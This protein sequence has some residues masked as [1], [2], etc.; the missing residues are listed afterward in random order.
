MKRKTGILLL[1]LGSIAIQ[2]QAQS[3]KLGLLMRE[4][5][6]L[7]AD[8]STGEANAQTRMQKMQIPAWGLGVW[9]NVGNHLGVHASVL[10][11]RAFYEVNQTTGSSGLIDA[12]MRFTQSNLHLEYFFAN[13]DK[14]T[15]PYIFGGIQHLYRRY[16]TERYKNNIAPAGSWP[17]SR[18]FMQT[19]LGMQF[20]ENA[21]MSVNVFAGLRFSSGNILVYDKKMNQIF[22]GLAISFSLQD[23]VKNR[24]SRCPDNF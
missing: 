23:A 6:N 22:A 10:L 3:L 13:K 24:Y 18:L 9:K 4:E 20:I 16:G 1:L 17:T 11:S 15:R 14:S 5:V 2:S 7:S 12:E 19:G 8:L 21:K